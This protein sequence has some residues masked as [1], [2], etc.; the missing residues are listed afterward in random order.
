MKIFKCYL[1]N[2]I[3]QEKDKIDFVICADC[4]KQT[5]KTIMLNSSEL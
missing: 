3:Y 5:K 2:K 4:S 1:C